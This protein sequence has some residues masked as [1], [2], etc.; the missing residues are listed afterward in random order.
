MTINQIEAERKHRA[1]LAKHSLADVLLMN[2]VLV[3]GFF[4]LLGLS[5][6]F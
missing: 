4:T 1:E 3:G 5:S 2:V 6:F